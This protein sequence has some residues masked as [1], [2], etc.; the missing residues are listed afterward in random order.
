MSASLDQPAPQYVQPGPDQRTMTLPEA[1]DAVLVAAGKDGILDSGEQREIQRM[2]S[3]LQAIAMQKAAMQ[4]QGQAQASDE[5]ED[6][7]ATEGS[8]PTDGSEPMPG[9]QFAG[10]GY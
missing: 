5:T 9:Q 1:V 7:G 3:G 6:F 2:M 4:Q 10:G 8:E